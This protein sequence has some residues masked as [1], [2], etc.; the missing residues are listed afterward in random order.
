MSMRRFP[1]RLAPVLAVLLTALFALTG[2]AAATHTGTVSLATVVSDNNVVLGTDEYIGYTF[3][4][5]AGKSIVYAIQ[6]VTGSNIDVFFFAPSGLATYRADPVDAS[7][8]ITSLTDRQQFGGTFT[9][10]TGAVT[11]IVDNVNGTG[12]APTGQVT[13][14]V[15]MTSNGRAPPPDFFSGILAIGLAICVGLIIL[16]VVVLALIIYLVTRQRS[17]PLPPPGPPYMPP[18]Q[19]PWPPQQP[20]GQYPPGNP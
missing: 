6:V 8:A 12:V 4:P 7:Q 1:S 3:T 5:S 13:V 17:P 10:A 15:G 2:P 16:V 14:Q 9:S 19:Q 20:P 11:V 18:P